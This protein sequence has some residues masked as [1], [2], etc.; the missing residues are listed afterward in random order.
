MLDF[1][2]LR[3]CHWNAYVNLALAESLFPDYNWSVISGEFHMTI[4]CAKETQ[5]IGRAK[6]MMRKETFY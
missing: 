5:S 2:C 3:T 4:I 6:V 1:V